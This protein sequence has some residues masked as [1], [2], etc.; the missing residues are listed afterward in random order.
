MQSVLDVNN[1]QKTRCKT[2]VI[3]QNVNETKL[4]IIKLLKYLYKYLDAEMFK[5]N[6]IGKKM[7]KSL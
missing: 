6:E 2:I 1:N 4:F 5:K 7:Q 3:K